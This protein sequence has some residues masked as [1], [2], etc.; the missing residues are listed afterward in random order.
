[1]ATPA[2]RSQN[3]ER[4]LRGHA[5]TQP[6]R[7]LNGMASTENTITR[8]FMPQSYTAETEPRD[9]LMTV[10]SRSA[11]ELLNDDYEVR[12]R[13]DVVGEGQQVE[14]PRPGCSYQRRDGA[15]DARGPEARLH[16]Q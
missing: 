7:T 12:G 14:P 13:C 5:N 2:N 3:L 6:M 11:P 1:M 8:T 15:V 16:G 9:Y 4:R 10:C